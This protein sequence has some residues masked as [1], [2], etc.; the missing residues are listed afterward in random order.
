MPDPPD[1][2]L[3]PVIGSVALLFNDRYGGDVDNPTFVDAK[4]Q[5]LIS[6]LLHI[7]YNHITNKLK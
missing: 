2:K 5:Y 4:T 6:N 7:Y 1:A 3:T